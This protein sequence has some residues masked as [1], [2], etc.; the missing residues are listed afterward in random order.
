MNFDRKPP[1]VPFWDLCW[2]RVP[3]Y[4]S[5]HWAMFFFFFN[6]TSYGQASFKNRCI[7]QASLQAL[8]DCI[9]MTS[10]LVHDSPFTLQRFWS[11]VFI[12]MPKSLSLHFLVHIPL[13]IHASTG[14]KMAKLPSFTGTIPCN[15]ASAIAFN[16]LPP[17]HIPFQSILA[18]QTGLLTCAVTPH[19]SRFL[20]HKCSTVWLPSYLQPHHSTRQDSPS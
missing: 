7:S 10:N 19:S 12:L 3:G 14:W 1:E 17:T 13:C 4:L 9:L 6:L 2:D 18:P 16:P 20:P 11:S 5:V 8:N 15:I